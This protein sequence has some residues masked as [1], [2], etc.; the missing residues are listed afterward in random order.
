MVSDNPTVCGGPL[1]GAAR[2]GY[3][4]G[5]TQYQALL[6]DQLFTEF[7]KTSAL[8]PASPLQM[9]DLITVYHV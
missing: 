4:T 6:L 9:T 5:V 8:N 7:H 3:D 1:E 2:D